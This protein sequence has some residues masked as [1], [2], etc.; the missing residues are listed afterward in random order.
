MIGAYLRNTARIGDGHERRQILAFAAER[1]RHPTADPGET[2]QREPGAHLILRRTVRIRLGGHPVQ[3]AHLVSQFSEIREQLADHLSRFA[4]RLKFPQRSD[5]VP[6]R[7]LEGDKLIV[8][9]QGLVVAFDEFRLVIE[10][11]EM[12]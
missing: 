2:V 5:Q 8:P 9:R 12:A 10:R 3:K 1:I 4:S 6:I 7:A 11:I